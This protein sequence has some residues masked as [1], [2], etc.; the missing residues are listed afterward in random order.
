MIDKLQTIKERNLMSKILIRGNRYYKDELDKEAF[1]LIKKAFL[2]I[3]S[4]KR[5]TYNL[6]YEKR[7]KEDIFNNK[8]NDN[9]YCKYLTDKFNISAYYLANAITLSNGILSSQA[10]LRK[11]YI[12]NKKLDIKKIR[13]PI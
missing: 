2:D 9:N 1:D 11:D 5:N 4:L 7:Y 6:L 12:F 13:Y 3:N 8:V 10:K